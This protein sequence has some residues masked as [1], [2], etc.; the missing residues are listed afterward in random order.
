MLYPL[1]KNQSSSGRYLNVVLLLVLGDRDRRLGQIEGSQW[2]RRFSDCSLKIADNTPL[3]ACVPP[4]TSA[5][6]A[7][8]PSAALVI[9]FKVSPRESDCMRVLRNSYMI[10]LCFACKTAGDILQVRSA[11]SAI[12]IDGV[13]SYRRVRVGQAVE[14]PERPVT[15]GKFDLLDRRKLLADEVPCVDLH[16][17]VECSSGTYRPRARSV[18]LV[19]RSESVVI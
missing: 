12:K 18:I 19:L 3:A 5:Q 13:R 8:P 11:V 16:M 7:R 15:I 1:E 4:R 9:R 17:V 2:S 10:F 6:P 14:L